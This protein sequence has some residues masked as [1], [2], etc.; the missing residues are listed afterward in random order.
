[1]KTINVFL[2]LGTWLLLSEASTSE[3]VQEMKTTII[4][5]RATKI[6]SLE[7]ANHPF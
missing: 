3:M 6:R 2:V 1:M 5:Y 7:T 4:S